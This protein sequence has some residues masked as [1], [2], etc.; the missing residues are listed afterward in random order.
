M[1]NTN[2]RKKT[3][4]WR[5]DSFIHLAAVSVSRAM[6]QPGAVSPPGEESDVN[7]RAPST[8]TM[9]HGFLLPGA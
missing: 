6:R 3:P 7:Q 8:M 1:G 4:N 5:Q 2:I 9:T